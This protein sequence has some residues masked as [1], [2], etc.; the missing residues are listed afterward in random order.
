MQHL[1]A[2]VQPHLAEVKLDSKPVVIPGQAP[3][4]LDAIAEVGVI[5]TAPATPLER[6]RT[7]TLAPD[8]PVEEPEE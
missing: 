1:E 4:R 7:L 3:A 6:L 2:E 8:D 5:P